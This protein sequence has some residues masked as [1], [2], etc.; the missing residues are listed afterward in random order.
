MI[1]LDTSSIIEILNGP[2]T[3]EASIDRFND[4]FAVT[5]PSIFELFHGIYR[6]KY[7][8]KKA[9]KEKVDNLIRDLEN[10]RDSLD[11]FPLSEKSANYAAKLHV[12]LLSIGKEID[13][14]DCL[15]GAIVLSNGFEKIV[16]NNVKHFNRI[17]GL[18][19]F[20]F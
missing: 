17:D 3:L 2:Q 9:S 18:K 6:Q 19:V 7:L 14:F 13:I 11:F 20:S 4:R 16:T 1:F 15:I 5:A 10:L 8:K 12:N